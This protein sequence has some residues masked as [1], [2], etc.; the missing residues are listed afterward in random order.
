MC[1]GV[2]WEAQGRRGAEVQRCKGAGAQRCRGAEMHRHLKG[3]SRER[4]ADRAPHSALGR[5]HLGEC[6]AEA[7]AGVRVQLNASPSRAAN[8][9]PH[10]RTWPPYKQ[11]D[12]E[13]RQNN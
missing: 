2:R 4:R 13:V 5:F 3:R 11:R 8:V 1:E 12:Q 9:Q 10:L 7:S 6:R